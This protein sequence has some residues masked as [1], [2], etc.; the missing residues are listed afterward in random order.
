MNNQLKAATKA[1]VDLLNSIEP[2]TK[3]VH[4]G[5]GIHVEIPDDWAERIAAGE[6]I[7]G[8]TYA[9]VQEDGSLLVD[10]TVQAELAKP[11]KEAVAA[12]LADV[13]IAEP[14]LNADQAKGSQ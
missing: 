5:A 14:V 6:D 13:V 9:R 4:V 7:P 12:R 2:P 10:E 11:G 1:D 3:G 8:C